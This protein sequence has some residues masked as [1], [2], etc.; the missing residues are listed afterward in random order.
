MNDFIKSIKVI[1]YDRLSSPLYGTFI[2][3][4]FLWNWKIWYVTFFVSESNLGYFPNSDAIII[5]KI[6]YIINNCSNWWTL[7]IYPVA[8]TIFLLLIMPLP[9]IGAFNITLR[10]EKWMSDIRN[11]IEKDKLLTLEQSTKLRKYI[12][13]QKDDFLKSLN[14][15]DEEIKYLKT[16]NENLE[17]TSN[18]CKEKVE[19]LEKERVELLGKVELLEKEKVEQLEKVEL[20]EKENFE[21]LRKAEQ[22]EKENFERLETFE[23]LEKEKIP[24]KILAA[25]YASG[26]KSVDISDELNKRIQNNCINVKIDNSIKGDPDLKYEKMAFIVYRNNGEIFKKII[27]ENDFFTIDNKRREGSNLIQTISI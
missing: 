2:V 26:R 24:L 17:K 5:N 13:E 7:L 25:F 21:Q 27:K 23:L 3:S 8:S 18:S 19:L 1:L 4:F 10:F 20:L 9:A 11:K 15:K 16:N 12:M 22:L 14:S 6:D